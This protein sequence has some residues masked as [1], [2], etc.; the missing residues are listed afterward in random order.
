MKLI[1][2]EIIAKKIVVGIILFLIPLALLAG[3]LTLVNQILK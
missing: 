1:D 2:F 3:G